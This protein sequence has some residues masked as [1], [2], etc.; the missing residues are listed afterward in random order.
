MPGVLESSRVPISL[1]PPELIAET[2]RDEGI[3]LSELEPHRRDDTVV[4]ENKRLAR[5]V[6]SLAIERWWLEIPEWRRLDFTM[7]MQAQTQWCWAATSVSVRLFY[8]PGANWTQCDMVNAE[9]GQTTCCTNGSSNQCNQP[10]VLDAPLDR[11][12]VLN[13]MVN[14]TTDYA[15]IR[16][17]INA[18][19]P[20]AWRI[21]WSGGGGHFAVIEGY[22]VIGGE[23][24]A[25]DDPWY[26]ASDVALTTLTGGTYQGTGS[27]THTYFTTRPPLILLP[28]FPLPFELPW[29]IWQPL[30]TGPGVAVGG[31]EGR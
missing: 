23:W 28:D 11:A 3:E 10:N 27:W 21:G 7:Q 14:S 9:L 18:G 29:A 24:V 15:T 5:R 4:L 16:D 20:L 26:G 17:E 25:V 30:L 31:G 8:T 13:R 2:A 19:R 22:R 1:L 6:F 12:D